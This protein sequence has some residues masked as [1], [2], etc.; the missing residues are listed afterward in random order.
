MPHFVWGIWKECNNQIFRAASLPTDIVSSKILN[1]LLENY[2]FCKGSNPFAGA[3]RST[4]D[5]QKRKEEC[6]WTFPTVGWHKE[7]FDAMA[8]GN[9]RQVGSG[10]VIQN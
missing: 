10:G 9:P 3:T 2:L 6:Q 8:K 5:T 4:N 1:A 7:I